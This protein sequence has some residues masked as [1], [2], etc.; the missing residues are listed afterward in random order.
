MVIPYN[1]F[2]ESSRFNSGPLEP[3]ALPW[4]DPGGPLVGLG[5]L[6]DRRQRVGIYAG[7]GCMAYAPMLV[8]LAELLQAPV[9]TSMA[10][11]G[12]MPEDH[13]LSVGWGYGP[14]GTQTAEQAFRQVDV[15][16]AM[17]V[18]F[19]E[20]ST[21]FYSLPQHRQLVHVDINR[22]NLGK[23]M[24]TSAAVNADA[25]MFMSQVIRQ[26]DLFRREPDARLLETI[27]RSRSE[28]T[29]RNARIESTDG[30]DP[31]ALI[32][33][34]RRLFAPDALTFVDVTMSQYWATEAFTATQARTFFNPTNNQNM[35]WSI[36]AAIGAQRV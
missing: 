1:L 3:A 31:M 8:Q 10:G 23:V 6:C 15:V 34:L 28:E 13:P 21:G 14:Q 32:L 7:Q 29:Q 18:K 30:V 27:R 9:A 35:G 12:V 5:Q 4:D 36:P 33:A 2:I 11:K 16:L 25:G 19:S 24:R 26:P 17:G 22:N 20:V